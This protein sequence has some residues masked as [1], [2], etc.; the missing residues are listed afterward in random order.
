M[1]SRP[2]RS[3]EETSSTRMS[4]RTLLT[5]QINPAPLT[6]SQPAQLPVSTTSS[7]WPMSCPRLSHTR[8][9]RLESKEMKRKPARQLSLPSPLLL[10][11]LLFSLPML[12]FLLSPTP[13]LPLSR[14]NFWIPWTRLLETSSSL[15]PLSCHASYDDAW[16]RKLCFRIARAISRTHPTRSVCCP[17]H[18]FA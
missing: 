10:L 3:P 12:S 2:K 7:S 18:I 16:P 11:L 8:S 6:L 14:H 5:I 9:T 15:H 1:L 4:V 17:E 13:S